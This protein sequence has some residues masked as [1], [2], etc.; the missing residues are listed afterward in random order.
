[1]TATINGVEYEL[2]DKG[3][4][5]NN[6]DYSIDHLSRL[7]EEVFVVKPDGTAFRRSEMI[8]PEQHFIAHEPI[9][10]PG[11]KSYF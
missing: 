7:P 3:L 6:F 1:M 10:F 8:F 5:R 11:S 2:V 4:V 9:D